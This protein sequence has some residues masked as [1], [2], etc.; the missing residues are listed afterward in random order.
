MRVSRRNMVYHRQASTTEKDKI[1]I[2]HNE[3]VKRTSERR[4][5][6]TT[7]LNPSLSDICKRFPAPCSI[8]IFI[9]EG[10]AARLVCVRVFVTGS[11]L[12]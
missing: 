3:R 11:T 5:L 9:V 12:R 1:E 2:I 7:F 10:S 8:T 4:Y 6:T